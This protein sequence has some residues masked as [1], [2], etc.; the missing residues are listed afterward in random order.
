MA[1]SGNQI[2]ATRALADV[3][4]MRL[5]Q[6]SGVGVKL[7][8]TLE[9]AGVTFTVGSKSAVNLTADRATSFFTC[10]YL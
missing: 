3:D 4:Q 8:K 5:A 1:I 7:Q 2:M 9:A 6:R 10:G